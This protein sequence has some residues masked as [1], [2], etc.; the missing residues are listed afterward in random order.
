MGVRKRNGVFGCCL[1]VFVLCAFAHY[2]QSADGNEVDTQ[3]APG[4]G[5]R[6]TVPTS[7]IVSEEL[8]L[9]AGWIWRS[10]RQGRPYNDTILARKRF[11]LATVETAIIRITADSDY[12][13]FINDRWVNDGPCRCWPDH[14]QYDVID[15]KPYLK[16]GE[17]EISV[18]ARFYGIGT[19]H[20]SPQEPGLLVQLDARETGGT[21]VTCVT[22]ASWEVT[23]AEGWIPNTPKQSVQVG[24]YEIYDARKANLPFEPAVVRHATHEGPWRGLTPRDVALMTKASLPF[25]ALRQVTVVDRAWKAS[26]FTIARMLYPDTVVT[27]SNQHSMSCALATIVACARPMTLS[28]KAREFRIHIDGRAAENDEFKLP[29]GKHLLF[30]VVDERPGHWRTDAG[31][32]FKELDGYALCNP[33]DGSVENPWCFVPFE[34][35]RYLCSEIDWRFKSAAEQ[36]SVIQKRKQLVDDVLRT[37]VDPKTFLRTFAGQIQT[38]SQVD[39]VISDVHG[40][41]VERTPLPKE[42][43]VL[44]DPEGCL[45]G[46]GA[47]TVIEPNRVGDIELCFDLGEQSC[48]YYQFEVDA[49]EGL[50]MDL[51][52]VEFIKPDGTIQHTGNYRNSMRYICK[53]GRNVF[54]SLKRRSQRYLFLTLRN[55]TQPVRIHRIGVIEST[56]PVQPVGRFACSDERLDKIWEISARTLKLCM[57]DT[58]TDCPLYEQALWVGDARNE[59]LFAYTAFGAEDIAR[60]SL[61]LAGRSTEK[62]PFVPSHVPSTWENLLPAWSFLWGIAVWDYYE[63]TGDDDFLRESWPWVIKNLEGTA[64]YRDKRGLF[65]GPFWNMFD[66]SG[67]D[68]GPNTVL[69]NSMLAVGAIDAALKCAGVLGKDTTWLR[70]YRNGLVSA[71]NGLWDKK[72]NA[73]P[74]SV[75]NDGKISPKTS[76]HT[77]FLALNYD[78]VPAEHRAAAINNIL[79]PPNGVTRVGAPFAMLYLYEAL[80]KLGYQDRIVQSI[81]ESYLP[82]LDQGATTVWEQFPSGT[83]GPKGFPTRSHCHAWSSAPVYFLNRIVLGIIPTE[84]AARTVTISPRPNGLRWAK[85]ASATTKGPVEVE[86]TIKEDLLTIRAKAPR[87][88]KLQFLPNESHKAFRV[89]FKA[90]TREDGGNPAGDQSTTGVP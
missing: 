24:P 16:A 67:I 33:V 47:V 71:V 5:G 39:D 18:V 82:M 76:M 51:A 44:Q 9:K 58:F 25:K 15:A 43:A 37:V 53:V 64:R 69:H 30:A 41:F 6:G 40:Q 81:Y 26:V 89:E 2:A 80:E 48:G 86:W 12:R 22:D 28:L 87:G 72:K 90:L 52:G 78:L 60:R 10:C 46:H 62:Y 45:A 32:R 8:P 31:I 70:E 79:Q 35:G 27:A 49:E 21:V 73:Y 74:D 19:Y 11:N 56:Y 66:W 57:E 77:S 85:G 59:A 20:R 14:H 1:C 7:R 38:L 13:L 23:R 84:V 34:K 88:V 68:Q 42:Q 29:A 61:R 17:N 75:Y 50:V 65:S 63:F 83:F 4:A 36:K 3:R 54:T 55:Q